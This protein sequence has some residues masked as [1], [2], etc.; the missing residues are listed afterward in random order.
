MTLTAGDRFE[1]LQLLARYAHATD[2]VDAVARADVFTDDG[3]FDASGPTLRGRAELLEA[4]RP[5]NAADLRHWVNNTLIEG[6]GELA[7]AVTYLTVFDSGASSGAPP[8]I[9][10]SGVYYDTV[11][12]VDGRWLFAYRNFVRDDLR[13]EQTLG[14]RL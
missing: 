5:E 4:R 14:F 2:G 6:D 1:I 3:V 10:L 11:R 8:Q 12:K 9:W 7:R 13:N